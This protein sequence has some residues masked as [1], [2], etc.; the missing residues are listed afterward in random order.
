LRLSGK[1][2]IIRAF[3]FAIIEIEKNYD[4]TFMILLLILSLYVLETQNIVVS[5]TE[6][7]T[8][9]FPEKSFQ[10]LNAH[11]FPLIKVKQR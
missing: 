8:E 10:L 3:W 11:T 5:L 6:G 9:E 4:D 7:F 2:E 1:F